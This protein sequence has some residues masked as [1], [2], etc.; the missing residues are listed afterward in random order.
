MAKDAE[1]RR[2]RVFTFREFV[3]RNFSAELKEGAPVLDVAGGR[4]DLSW[5]LTNADGVDAVVVDPRVTDF[6]KLQKTAQWHHD[7]RH[8]D[9]ASLVAARGPQGPLAELRLAPPFRAARHLRTFLDQ[10]L[11]DALHAAAG[12]SLEGKE[13]VKGADTGAEAWAAFWSG[14]TERSAAL[15]ERALGHHQPPASAAASAAT[16]AGRIT[17]AEEAL[18]VLLAPG[19]LLGFHPDEATEPL[20]DLALAL[21]R[22]FAVVPCCVFPSLFPQ[23]RLHGRQVRSHTDFCDYLQAKH[24]AI[25]RGA[26]DFGGR[27]DAE[28]EGKGEGEE[29][30]EEAVGAAAPR[31]TVL[32]MR[33]VDYE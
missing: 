23:R 32:F 13:A 30:G 21:R 5:V 19:L 17:S 11:L 10:A 20:V 7:H 15:E 33:S 3:L 1:P 9:L 4:G 27:G 6:T 14:A 26:L 24:P 8:E 29:E 31:S 25:R 22:P 2:Q 12:V 18:R 16:A 28:G